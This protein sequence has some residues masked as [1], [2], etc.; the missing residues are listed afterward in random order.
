MG[1][2]TKDDHDF[3]A[4]VAK[5]GWTVKRKLVRLPLC[6]STYLSFSANTEAP[7]TALSLVCFNEFQLYRALAVQGL[8]GTPCA[9][10]R[11]K[12]TRQPSKPTEYSKTMKLMADTCTTKFCANCALLV[13]ASIAPTQMLVVRH[14]CAMLK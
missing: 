7:A 6:R 8:C 4:E 9:K 10:G 11:S 1:W 5:H 3:P 12:P 13:L 2:T 14:H